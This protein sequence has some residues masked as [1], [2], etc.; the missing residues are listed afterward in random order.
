MTDIAL[1]LQNAISE[2][3]YATSSRFID[4]TMKKGALIDLVSGLEAL[5]EAT[6]HTTL[7]LRDH[8]FYFLGM[9]D[10]Y[11]AVQMSSTDVLKLLSINGV[12][13]RAQD[14]MVHYINN[15]L[16]RKDPRF[17]QFCVNI[18]TVS[19]GHYAILVPSILEQR[20]EELLN[21]EIQ[22]LD[23]PPRLYCTADLLNTY[24]GQKIVA[25]THG[26]RSFDIVVD[27]K[28]FRIIRE[29]LESTGLDIETMLEE[30]DSDNWDEY[31]RSRR[32]TRI[33][34]YTRDEKESH[35]ELASELA[36][37]HRVK[38]ARSNIYSDDFNQQIAALQT[39]DSSKTQL[40]N[41]VLSD[42]AMNP[43][44]SLRKRAL[45]QLGKSGDLL[46]LDLLGDLMKNDASSA[47]RREAARA[48]ST[49]SSRAAGL[50]QLAPL[51]SSK[52]PSVDVSR[53]NI[54]L[55]NLISRRMPATMIDEA[56]HSFA[57]Q[58]GQGSGELLL[59]L[60]SHPDERIRGSIVRTTRT[61]DR[62][63][64]APIV[65]A[66]LQD[67]SV[68]IVKLAENELDSRWPDEVW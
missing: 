45:N 47:I 11:F 23:E 42:I 5:E 50:K 53:I 48:F 43:S 10:V 59:R 65:R 54:V 30:I 28:Q 24:Y 55:N 40:C 41:D 57:L 29:S 68:E 56:L 37:L 46:T 2:G 63:S 52:P 6:S 14:F 39:I 21:C 62:E 26:Q 25:A 38:S 19:R 18:Q 36:E 13:E 1:S 51:P 31:V 9:W 33:K 67:E 17:D 32:N 66:A 12:Q 3:D 35:H 60:F 22:Y 61:L 44:H 16:D 7:E 34:K 20:T 8:V 27:E 4:W 58:G 49:L 15:L 64:A